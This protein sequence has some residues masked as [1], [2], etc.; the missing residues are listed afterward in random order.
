MNLPPDRPATGARTLPQVGSEFAGYLLEGVLGRG[1][2]SVV[3]RASHPRLGSTVALKVLA[4]ELT[5]DDVFRER[6]VRESRAAAALTHPNIVP[7]SEA[8][9]RDGFLYLV[10]R[11]VESDLRSVLQRAGPLAPSARGRPGRSDRGRA[12]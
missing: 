3:Y 9:E 6:F 1:G 7:I 4:P 10:M 11:H 8:G 12:A 5:T 2:M